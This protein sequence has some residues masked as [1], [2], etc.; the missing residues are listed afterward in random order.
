MIAIN[1]DD[2]TFTF[3][4]IAGQVRGL[5]EEHVKSTLRKLILPTDREE[6]VETLQAFL[7]KHRDEW[8]LRSRRQD[9]DECL[10]QTKPD[11]TWVLNLESLDE[12]SP[13]ALLETAKALTPAD[14]EA[15]PYFALLSKLARDNGLSGLSMGMSGDFETAIMLGATHIRVGS[16]LFGARG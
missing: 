6:L 16:A 8:E 11:G 13:E 10:I 3:P 14:V 9:S 2:L 15:A 5:F 7:R 12:D 1:D 4:E